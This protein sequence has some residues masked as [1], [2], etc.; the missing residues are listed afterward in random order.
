MSQRDF[1][2]KNLGKKKKKSFSNE[3]DFEKKPKS[4]KSKKIERDF[5]G[6]LL[7]GKEDIF[8][9]RKEDFEKGENF[10]FPK[11]SSNFVDYWN[12]VK[13]TFWKYFIKKN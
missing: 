1:G 7:K 8:S 4:E 13:L 11:N 9:L 5:E 2:R 3:S 12:M 6:D 10:N